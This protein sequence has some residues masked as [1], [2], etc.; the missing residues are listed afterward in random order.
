VHFLDA[1]GA[2]VGRATNPRPLQHLAFVPERP[3]LIASADFGSVAAFSLGGRRRW[4]DAP[5]AHCGAL[6]TSGDGSRIALACFSDG[7][8][9]YHHRGEKRRD[10]PHLGP[11]RLVALAYDGSALLT[12]G[13]DGC[14]RL[15]KWDGQIRS[16]FRPDAAVTSLAL[17]A[18]GNTALVGLADGKVLAL[19]Q[20]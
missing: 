8:S 12:A 9:F 11:C 5:V 1:A 13:L 6:A 14:V 10:G 19:T 3:L 2:G 7:V 16:D 4:H 18:L 15:H 20:E 17:N